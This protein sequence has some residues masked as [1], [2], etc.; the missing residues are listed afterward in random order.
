VRKPRDKA[1]VEQG[2]LLAEWWVLAARN[3]KLFSLEEAW[4]EY[5]FARA[6]YSRRPHIRREP[7]PRSP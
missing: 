1:K 4:P 3:R 2:V 5:A 6:N 7:G